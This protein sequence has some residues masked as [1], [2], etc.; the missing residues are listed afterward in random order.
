[1][2]LLSLTPAHHASLSSLHTTPLYLD[3]LL[4][5][6]TLLQTFKLLPFIHQCGIKAIETNRCRISNMRNKNDFHGKHSN[7]THRNVRE[8]F[9]RE[10]RFFVDLTELK[11][12]NMFCYTPPGCAQRL[13]TLSLIGLIG[14]TKVLGSIFKG[15]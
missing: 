2:F 6:N 9:E 14:P 13:A 15:I 7:M 5:L 3:F 4:R 1:M 12:S 8:N 11:M 10:L